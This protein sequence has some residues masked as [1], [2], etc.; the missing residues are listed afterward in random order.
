M[1]PA[2]GD[3]LKAKAADRRQ[4]YQTA[5]TVWPASANLL[6]KDLVVCAALDVLF[7][8]READDLVFKGGTSLSKAHGLISRFSEDIDLVVVRTALGIDEAIDPVNA[9]A[10]LSNK[11]R[12]RALKEL[13][14]SCADY[15]QTTIK[16]Q[17]EEAF[18]DLGMSVEVDPLEGQTLLLSYPSVLDQ[19]DGYVDPIVKLEGGARS[20]LLP[21]HPACVRPYVADVLPDADLDVDNVMTI[22]AERTFLDKLVILHGRHCRFRDSGDIYRNAKRESRHY[23]DLALMADAVGPA[24]V[25]KLDLLADVVEHS[26]IA[27]GSG[28]MRLDQAAAGELLILPPAGMRDAIRRDYNAMQ[29][30]IFG[31]APSFDAVITKLEEIDRAFNA[32]R[33][34]L[35]AQAAT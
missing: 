3:F 8:D 29:G 20:A 25:T 31:D 15:I 7:N 30:M 28:W 2:Y 4:V 24:A 13:Q 35:L 23:Y 17:L 34:K 9:E 1:K 27:F 14:A 22:D 6:E 12:E 18:A 19:R 10:D 5:G 11:R 21:S 33:N 32:H 26:R 16:P